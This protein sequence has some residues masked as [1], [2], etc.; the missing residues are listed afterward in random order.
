MVNV[1]SGYRNSKS[2]VIYQG[3]GGGYFVRAP[4]GGK[5]YNPKA[6]KYMNE[7][8]TVKNFTKNEGNLIPIKLRPK[9]IKAGPRGAPV[10][11]SMSK[12]E[13]SEFNKLMAMGK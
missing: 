10:R 9:K 8:G 2:R 1:N 6:T 11:M 12:K 7:N 3:P 5:Q 13:R 4:G